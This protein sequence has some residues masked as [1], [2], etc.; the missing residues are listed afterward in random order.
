MGW[1]FRETNHLRNF[2]SMG[3]ASLDPSY[4]PIDDVTQKTPRPTG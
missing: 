2:Q 4:G 1:D 3:V